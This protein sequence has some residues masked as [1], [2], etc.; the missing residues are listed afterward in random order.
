M[1]DCLI[2]MSLYLLYI[3]SP[4]T[5]F[6]DTKL[7]PSGFGSYNILPRGPPTIWQILTAFDVLKL[8]QCLPQDIFNGPGVAGAVL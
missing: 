1:Y 3:F 5:Y 8:A 4:N 2:S 7:L 6:T